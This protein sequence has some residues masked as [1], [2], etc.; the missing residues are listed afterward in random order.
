MTERRRRPIVFIWQKNYL[1]TVSVHGTLKYFTS[2]ISD[3][4]SHTYDLLDPQETLQIFTQS[5]F[6][7]VD[8]TSAKKR[9]SVKRNLEN[10]ALVT[11]TL[12]KQRAVFGKVIICPCYCIVFP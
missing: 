10:V 7:D 3:K 2:L 1:I 8:A 4:I 9:R 11:T 5:A 12:R 6:Y